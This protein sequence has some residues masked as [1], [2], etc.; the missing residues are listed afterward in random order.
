M[1]GRERVMAV[2]TH[3][4]EYQDGSVLLDC[5]VE[6]E[7]EADVAGQVVAACLDEERPDMFLFHVGHRVAL[8]DGV[9]G[10]VEAE[11]NVPRDE[12]VALA[13]WILGRAGV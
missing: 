6:P 3:A 4:T 10:E 1:D 2:S 9:A 7:C 13:R 8:P 12:A 11:V 5:V